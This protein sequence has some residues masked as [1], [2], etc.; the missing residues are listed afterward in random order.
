[1]SSY[2]APKLFLIKTIV[3]YTYLPKVM[4]SWKK[5]LGIIFLYIPHFYQWC[6]F[7]SK[8]QSVVCVLSGIVAD[9]LLPPPPLVGASDPTNLSVGADC[10]SSSSVSRAGFIRPFLSSFPTN[11]AAP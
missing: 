5:S 11:V 9:D 10:M 2:I 4:G 3:L 8:L 7:E 1:M 6:I